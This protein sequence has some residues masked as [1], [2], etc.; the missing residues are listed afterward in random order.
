[1]VVGDHGP[2][3]TRRNRG[4]ARA[5]RGSPAVLATT[6]SRVEQVALGR[7]PRRVA[8]H[9]GPA[10]H[11]GDR[12]A[13]VALEV[14]QAEDRDQVADVERR[15]GRV[16]ADVAERRP[17]RGAARP[18][19]A[20]RVEEASPAELVEKAAEPGRRRSIVRR[21]RHSRRRPA[22]TRRG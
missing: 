22:V 8:D 5:G 4:S 21:R 13:T 7:G 20:C 1:M 6:I 14:E 2:V 9:P 3:G 19:R 10:A 12:P 15:P 16:E 17:D 11:Q 18:G